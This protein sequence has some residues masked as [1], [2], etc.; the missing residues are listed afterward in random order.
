MKPS[1]RLVHGGHRLLQLAVGRQLEQAPVRDGGDDAR[2]QLRQDLVQMLLDDVVVGFQRVHIGAE[3]QSGNRVD[4]EAHQVG[5]QV[6]GAASSRRLGPAP[7]QAITALDQ[8][9]V[10]GLDMPGVEGRHDHAALARPDLAVHAEQA[11]LEAHLQADRPCGSGSS[12]RIPVPIG[13]AAD[14]SRPA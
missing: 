5:L 3:G 9:R 4:G 6:D 1:D 13:R 12:A 7:G 8:R 2:E 14:A 10:V 11:R